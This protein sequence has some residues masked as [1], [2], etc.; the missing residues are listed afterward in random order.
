LKSINLQLNYN[1]VLVLPAAYS[2][3]IAIMVFLCRRA[4]ATIAEHPIDA[5]KPAANESLRT[6]VTKRGFVI[7]RGLRQEVTGRLRKPT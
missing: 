6:S 2:A 3:K 1:N 4:Y 7:V 5:Q